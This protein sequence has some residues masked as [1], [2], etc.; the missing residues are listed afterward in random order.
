MI[1]KEAHIIRRGVEAWRRIKRLQRW[2][3][4]TDFHDWLLVGTAMQIGLRE[5]QIYATIDANRL[6]QN[7]CKL[8]GFD[9]CDHNIKTLGKIVVEGRVVVQWWLTNDYLGRRKFN[10]PRKVWA[11]YLYFKNNP[12]VSHQP[13]LK[14][15][16]RGRNTA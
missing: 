2:H 9:T 16:I 6:Y 15:R 12:N 7:W 8:H 4:R 14:Y 10:T 1:A 5:A 3:R 13:K 11:R